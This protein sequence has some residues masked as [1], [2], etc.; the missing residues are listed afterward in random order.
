MLPCTN[1][2]NGDP[3]VFSSSSPPTEY[4]HQ[5]QL[6]QQQE[7]SQHLDK[8]NDR[9]VPTGYDDHPNSHQTAYP[10]GEAPPDEHAAEDKPKRTTRRH[11]SNNPNK[12]S[13]FAMSPDFGL[14]DL[15]RQALI[16]LSLM[17]E[18]SSAG[19][20]I[21][22]D[23]VISVP[24]GRYLDIILNQLRY[25][26]VSCSFIQLSSPFHPHLCHGVLPYA[27]LMKFI[28]SATFGA[29][30]SEA[31]EIFP[32]STDSQMNIYHNAFLA[33]SFH[34]TL[35]TEWT[36][37]RPTQVKKPG[38]WVV[39][40]KCFFS[41]RDMPIV[42]KQQY[43]NILNV[44]HMKVMSC[45]LREG[46]TIKEVV[47]S[48]ETGLSEVTLILPWKFL[49]H[50][51]YKIYMNLV[52]GL[53]GGDYVGIYN[54]TSVPVDESGYPSKV[55]CVVSLE[56]PYD[57]LHDVTCLAKKPFSSLYRQLM[58][59]RFWAT[60][61][62]LSE[63]DRL[64]VHLNSFS[65]N[66][67]YYNIPESLKNGMPLFYWGS[68]TSSA[69]PHLHSNEQSYPQFTHFWKP[70]CLLDTT[71]WQKWMHTH[72]I[73][74]ILEHDYPLPKNLHLPNSTGRFNV[75]QCRQAVMAL[76]TLLKKMSSFVL[77]EN[78]SYVRLMF[79]NDEVD[80]V[81]HSFCLIR[82]TSKPPHV[83]LRL[84]FLVGTPGHLRH[85]TV[86]LFREKI[87]TLTFPQRVKDPPK[88][89]V[90]ITT[91]VAAKAATTASPL[92]NKTS[93][94]DMPCCLLVHK[95][96]E[97]ILIRYDKAPDDF[98]RRL[99]S[100]EETSSMFQVPESKAAHKQSTFGFR[101]TYQ[102]APV[103]VGTN[104]SASIQ[105][106][107]EVFNT[108]AR[109]LHHRRWIW[110][111]PPG[112]D[113][114][115]PLNVKWAS[116]ILATVTKTRLQEGFRFAY[117]S[118]G[119]T[120]M[121]LELPMKNEASS[122]K[123]S[124]APMVLQFLVFPPTSN[125][126]T[127]FEDLDSSDGSAANS[128]LY[129]VTECWVEPQCGHVTEDTGGNSDTEDLPVIA[130]NFLDLEYTAIPKLVWNLHCYSFMRIKIVRIIVY[131][132]T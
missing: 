15:L 4:T 35:Q 28:A 88:W 39:R 72:R 120:N 34:K 76:N 130:K 112:A 68:A 73:G 52:D 27:D 59:N 54:D 109:Y 102:T 75:I 62:N 93:W 6:Q 95:P 70:V 37:Q 36:K 116:E 89:R 132:I 49:I 118:S 71:V 3:L 55:R 16:A 8:D 12:Y 111:F 23:G 41:V 57:F 48:K 32:D 20:V 80:K 50:L 105:M 115:P 117:S 94:S 85:R 99:L 125:L 61:K 64:L 21:L 126:K 84:A 31:P 18:N 24:D 74:V 7:P 124:V 110:W 63:S 97:K 69:V 91:P 96:V 53:N 17:P 78:Q 101:P 56:G 87:A 103:T 66:P 81:P 86:A 5:Q 10:E 123:N 65:A 33:W 22:T 107:P 9:H 121:V 38:E 14:L 127:D 25:N 2:D 122:E 128:S 131:T 19:L 79:K 1:D 43:E 29:F 104:V 114:L 60:R 58:V 47:T 113:D 42:K 26:T 46:F 11:P 44:D 106:L 119:I 30:L 51:E 98:R 92:V 129:L 90:I 67:A 40:N 100:L 108:I 83:V 82:V 13:S 45:R 77:L